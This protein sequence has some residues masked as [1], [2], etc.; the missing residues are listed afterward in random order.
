MKPVIKLSTGLFHIRAGFIIILSLILLSCG[1]NVSV[2]PELSLSSQHGPTRVKGKVVYE[3]NPVYL[4]TT[5]EHVIGTDLIIKY[6]YAL[7]YSSTGNV[8]IMTAFVPTTLLGTPTGGDWVTAVGK[9]EIVRD[10][11]VLKIYVGE[12]VVSKPRS[13]FAGGVDK[14]ELRRLALT[15]LKENIELQMNNDYSLFL[16][17]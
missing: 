2:K 14:T 6:E 4:P 5:V 13:L 12:V 7:S 11:K 1:A 8:E 10:N 9:L 15:N 17:I 16:K 3:G